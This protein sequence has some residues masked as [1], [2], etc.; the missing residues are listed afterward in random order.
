MSGEASSRRPIRPPSKQRFEKKRGKTS[1]KT[2]SDNKMVLFDKLFFGFKA[3]ADVMQSLQIV[4]KRSV[5]LPM[6][7]RGIG[8]MTRYLM[9]RFSCLNIPNI[10]FH[11]LCASVYRVTLCMFEIKLMSVMQNQNSLNIGHNFQNIFI[12]TDFVRVIGSLDSGFSP[13][14]NLISSIGILRAYGTT[15]LPRLP[16][17]MYV[18][19]LNVWDPTLVSFTNL[20]DFVDA[21][22]N[23]LTPQTMRLWFY[24]HSP[25]PCVVWNRSA[26]I[27]NTHG[28]LA[29]QNWPLLMNPDHIMPPGFDVIKLRDDV[30]L[31]ITSLETIERKYPKYVFI[32]RVE[33]DEPGVASQLVSN[34]TSDARCADLPDLPNAYSTRPFEGNI[35]S[36]WSSEIMSD[37]EFY[38]GMIYLFG[39]IPREADNRW[40]VRQPDSCKNLTDSDYLSNLSYLVNIIG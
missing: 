26:G 3:Q 39:E 5:I 27:R 9:Q 7:T 36:F 21:L 19:G 8:F 10:D 15:F 13:L 16:A 28:E 14:V 34:D 38:M 2:D 35:T 32:G 37:P 17:M 1:I 33:Y 23:P 29:D 22:S 18:D 6:S 40:A 4:I 25:I 31:I 30:D 11:N 20:R 12:S 24:N